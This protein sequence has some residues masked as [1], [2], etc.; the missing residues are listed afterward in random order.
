MTSTLS[1]VL[2]FYKDAFWE[3]KWIKSNLRLIFKP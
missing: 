2:I 3:R 1:D